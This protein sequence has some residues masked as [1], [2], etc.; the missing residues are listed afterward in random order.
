MALFSNPKNSKTPAHRFIQT[1]LPVV[2][3]NRV[4][5]EA[6]AKGLSHAAWLR[7]KIIEIIESEDEKP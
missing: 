5:E 7:M 3:Y 1:R 6:K 4:L 2:I